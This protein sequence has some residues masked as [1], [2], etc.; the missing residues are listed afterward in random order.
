MQI[1]E[2]SDTSGLSIDTI[3]FYEKSGMLPPVQ[4]DGRGWRRFDPSTIEWLLNLERLRATGMPMA[5]MKRFAELVHERDPE[6]HAAAM[7]RLDILTRHRETLKQ[8]QTE[9]DEC[10]AYLEKKIRVYTLR[11]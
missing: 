1:R 7:E 5:D 4:R 6:D 3:R 9:L 8:R 2:A 11:K 10:A